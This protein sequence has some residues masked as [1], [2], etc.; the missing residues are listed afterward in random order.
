MDIGADVGGPSQ[1]LGF[2]QEAVNS[3]LLQPLHPLAF[4]PLEFE[5]LLS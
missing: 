3:R 1:G 2:L 4:L 5:L